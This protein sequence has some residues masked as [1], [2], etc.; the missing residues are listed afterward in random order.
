[1]NVCERL[2]DEL[3]KELLLANFTIVSAS[4]EVRDG[5]K[6]VKRRAIVAD[7]D[8]VSQGESLPCL[9]RLSLQ[10][11]SVQRQFIFPFVQVAAFV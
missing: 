1:M 7:S 5:R 6:V 8:F 11:L 4:F 3:V 10:F 9:G 2:F